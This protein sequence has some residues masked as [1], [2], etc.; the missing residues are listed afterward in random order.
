MRAHRFLCLTF[1]TP[2]DKCQGAWFLDHMVRLCLVLN[3][4]NRLSSKAAVS[5]CIFTSNEWKFLFHILPPFVVMSILDFAHFNK[6]VV[7]SVISYCFLICISLK[8]YD[9]DHLLICIWFVYI[10]LFVR[11]LLR[12]LTHFLIQ[13]FFLMLSFKIFCYILNKYTLSDVS[14][15]NV[16]SVFYDLSFHSLD[17]A[18]HRADNFNEVQPIFLSWIAPLMLHEKCHHQAP[19]HLCFLLC[20]L[21]RVSQFCT[22]YLGLWSILS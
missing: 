5:F 16:F 19:D 15:A 1:S 4:I 3:E 21:L 22:L 10:C 17:I 14:F 7:I 12:F 8:T 2:L 6:Y 20:Y 11:C 9:M 18:S 13:F